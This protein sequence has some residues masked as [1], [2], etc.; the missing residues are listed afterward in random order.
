MNWS[1]HFL[2]SD[3]K[4]TNQST[5]LTNQSTPINSHPH[6]RCTLIYLHGCSCNA[7]QYLE[8]GWELPW[9]GKDEPS[10]KST[11]GGC[12]RIVG[13]IFWRDSLVDGDEVFFPKEK[14]QILGRELEAMTQWNHNEASCL[15]CQ[16]QPSFR[17]DGCRE[18]PVLPHIAGDHHDMACLVFWRGLSK[19]ILPCKLKYSRCKQFLWRFKCFC[20]VVYFNSRLKPIWCI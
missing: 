17:V 3:K 20:C 18:S 12:G 1:N 2:G 7:G 5:N 6:F 13:W 19:V 4:M 9:T 16:I 8:D 10:N 11:G 15:G 14:P